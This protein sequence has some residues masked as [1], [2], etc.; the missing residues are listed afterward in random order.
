M[1]SEKS[2]YRHTVFKHYVHQRKQETKW[3]TFT[4][5]TFVLAFILKIPPMNFDFNVKCSVTSLVIMLSNVVE[6]V[7]RVS[8]LQSTANA[9]QFSVWTWGTIRSVFISV[10]VNVVA[11]R[12]GKLSWRQRRETSVVH[13][14]VS[15]STFLLNFLLLL[16]MSLLPVRGRCSDSSVYTVVT[17]FGKQLY[18]F[19]YTEQ[20]QANPETDGSAHVRQKLL[21]LQAMND[22]NL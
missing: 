13:I 20:W 16:F 2:V 7:S 21:H 8:V 18:E 12:A 11:F 6:I 4:K 10:I 22:K 1:T 14:F 3:L 17:E 9:R 5:S 15:T 19:H